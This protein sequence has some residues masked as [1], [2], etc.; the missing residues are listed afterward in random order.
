MVV[1]IVVPHNS[2]K[3]DV[4]RISSYIKFSKACR[5]KNCVALSGRC[6][7]YVTLALTDLSFSQVV[8]KDQELC[9]L[10]LST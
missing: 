10:W 3:K 1:A 8:C 6:L 9:V 7:K 4:K 5:V 2:C